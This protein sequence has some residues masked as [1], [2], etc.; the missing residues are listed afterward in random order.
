MWFSNSFRMFLISETSVQFSHSVVSDSLRSQELQHARP[1]CPL[2]TPEVY[3][4]SCPSS[5][6]CHPAIS[7]SVIS[8]SCPNPSQHQ[9]L[10]QWVNSL[11]EVAK[12]LEFQLQHQSG[13]QKHLA[14][15]F[16]MFFQKWP[17]CLIFFSIKHFGM[18]KLLKRSSLG[19]ST[20]WHPDY[21]D[22]EG[23][24]LKTDK[25]VS[26]PFKHFAPHLLWVQIWCINRSNSIWWPIKN[27]L[28]TSYAI[29]WAQEYKWSSLS[30]DS[31]SDNFPTS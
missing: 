16:L 4:N 15:F 8:F 30:E 7:F 31:V 27:I 18:L 9:G 14:L 1:P 21:G 10:F 19:K 20:E 3:P 11:H 22:Q 25:E 24:H 28:G 23:L 12:V 29:A 2:P 5:W 17:G 26:H 13:D 6:W